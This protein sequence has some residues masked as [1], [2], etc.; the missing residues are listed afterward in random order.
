MV[1]ASPY[2]RAGACVFGFVYFMFHIHIAEVNVLNTTNAI[3]L[4]AVCQASQ[5]HISMNNPVRLAHASNYRQN[6][7][8][9]TVRRDAEKVGTRVPSQESP[10]ESRKH[11]TT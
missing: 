2:G 1:D 5:S 8:Y 11:R 3:D 6:N 4:H 9:P 10:S 7:V